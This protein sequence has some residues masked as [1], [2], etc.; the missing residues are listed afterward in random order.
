[1]TTNNLNSAQSERP[2]PLY[3]QIRGALREKI[4]DGGYAHHARLPSESDLMQA[5]GVSRI[6]VRQALRDLENEQLIF[7]VPGKGAF[8]SKPRPS[9]ELTRLQGF[10]EAM[11]RLGYQTVNRL[12]SLRELP[13]SASIA[14]RLQLSPGAPVVEIRRVRLVEREPISVDLTYV[15]AALGQRL[16]R[17]DLVN[18]DIF[19]I[20]ENDYAIP[21][22]HADLAIDATTA[23]PELAG[24]LGVSSGSPLL[25][26]ERLTHDKD[27]RPL[28][29]EHLYCRGDAFRFSLRVER[30]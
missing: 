20:I 23:S 11:S 15:P 3:A 9:Q 4:L 7:K 26:I 19:L 14:E 13:A 22:G 1:M 30:Q 10:G 27:G 17:E 6:T 18:R 21:L 24:E 29:Y 5:Y 16:A 28:D 25:H 8:V 12:L 2:L